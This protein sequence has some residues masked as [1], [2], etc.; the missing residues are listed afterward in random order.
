[1]STT[2]MIGRL[3]AGVALATATVV[4]TPDPAPATATHP[5][6]SATYD[7]ARWWDAY[8]FGPEQ[9]GVTTY[10]LREVHWWGSH[11]VDICY[12]SGAPAWT[13][14]EMLYDRVSGARAWVSTG[15][16]PR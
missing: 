3:A 11:Q 16:C 1:M 2:T 13:F 15:L 9:N 6:T 8:Y 12:T 4:A 7:I 5:V 10:T 14:A